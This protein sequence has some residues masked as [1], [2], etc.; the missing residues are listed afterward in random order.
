MSGRVLAF[1]CSSIISRPQ[2]EVSRHYA[3]S[4]DPKRVVPLRLIR[5]VQR[6]TKPFADHC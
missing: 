6:Y 4:K 5:F 1:V 2:L 3:V